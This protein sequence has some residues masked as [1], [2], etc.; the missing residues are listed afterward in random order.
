MRDLQ[1]FLHFLILKIKNFQILFLIEISI[2]Y[3]VNYNKFKKLLSLD[4]FP[5]SLSKFIFN[6]INC[7][8]YLD[9]FY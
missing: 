6:V 9:K 8:I 2:F 4:Y 3:Y 7:K 1:I 5:N